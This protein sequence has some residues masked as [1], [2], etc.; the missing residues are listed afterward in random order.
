M[1]KFLQKIRWQPKT[2]EVFAGK[3]DYPRYRFIDK[4]MI[5]FIMWLT[6]G[7]TDTTKSFE[8]TNWN[9][10]AIFSQRIEQM[11]TQSTSSKIT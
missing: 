11:V 8:F 1:Q 6:K 2:M 10:V 3:L 7:P 5:R 4:H 9:K